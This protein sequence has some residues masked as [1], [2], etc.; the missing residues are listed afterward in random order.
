MVFFFHEWHQ[1]D[2]IIQRN[3]EYPLFRV[4]SLVR[5]VQDVK[6]PTRLN[7]N[8]NAFERQ[9]A[10]RLQRVVLFGTPPKT[11][12]FVILPRCVPFVTTKDQWR[13]GERRANER[14]LQDRE[15]GRAKP[16]ARALLIRL[17]GRYPHTVKRLAAV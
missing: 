12:H 6:Q 11:L 2:V 17:G 8:S 4:F 14:T 13:K 7:R 16:N 9:A 5:M 3:H 1:I 10:V 15:Q